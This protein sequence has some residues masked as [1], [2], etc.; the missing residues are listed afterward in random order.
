M[1]D[2]TISQLA[3][4][5][6]KRELASNPEQFKPKSFDLGLPKNPDNSK[7]IDLTLLSRLAAIADAGGTYLGTKRG[8]AS[9]NNA[10]VNA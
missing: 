2:S 8:L 6:L 9:E 3:E 10:V 5:L 1:A 7:E 4:E